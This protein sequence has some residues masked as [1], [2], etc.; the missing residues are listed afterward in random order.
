MEYFGM[1][2]N[3]I[4]FLVSRKTEKCG[5]KFICSSNAKKVEILLELNFNYVSVPISLLIF[6]LK[7][8]FLYKQI[9]AELFFYQNY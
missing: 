3:G 8:I 1:E 2:F 6:S 7:H 9:I 4:N 5:K